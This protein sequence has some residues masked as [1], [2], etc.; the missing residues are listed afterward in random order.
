MLFLLNL[1]LGDTQHAIPQNSMAD[2]NRIL[3]SVLTVLGLARI[4]GVAYAHPGPILEAAEDGLQDF[5]DD[6]VARHGDEMGGVEVLV[7]VLVLTILVWILKG[8][9]A[10]VE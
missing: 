9:M 4:I 7:L 8:L 6:Q 3:I 5:L 1:H 2:R 10:L